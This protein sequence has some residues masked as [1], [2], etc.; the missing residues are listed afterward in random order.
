MRDRGWT[1]VDWLLTL[2]EVARAGIALMWEGTALATA[3]AEI[4][5]NIANV[6]V[7]YLQGM[8]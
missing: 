1:I 8:D 6:C 7:C 3:L 5:E 2:A 4:L